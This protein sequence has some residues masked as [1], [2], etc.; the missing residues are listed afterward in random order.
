MLEFILNGGPFMFAILLAGLITILLGVERIYSLF[1]KKNHSPSN[2]R[3]RLLSI[4]FLGSAAALTGLIGTVM[5]FY[6][7]FAAQPAMAEAFPIYLVCKIAIST[8]IAGLTTGLIALTIHFIVE[9]KASRVE[10]MQLR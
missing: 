3:K 10:A 6:Q 8:T 5:G 4:K 9:A 2:L 7:A 1:I